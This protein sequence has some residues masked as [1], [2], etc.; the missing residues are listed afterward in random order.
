MQNF[1]YLESK[2]ADYCYKR[3]ND[4]HLGFILGNEVLSIE[5]IPA[6]WPAVTIIKK[7]AKK[8]RKEIIKTLNEIGFKK[9]DG[10]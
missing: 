3:D 2:N 8:Y 7:P 6:N 5:F 1:E 4:W 10:F 9:V